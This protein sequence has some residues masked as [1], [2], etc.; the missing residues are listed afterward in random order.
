M[1]SAKPPTMLGGTAIRPVERHGMDKVKYFLH[2][3][4]TGEIMSRT[5]LSWLLITVFYVIY[6]LCLAAFWTICMVIFLQ[7]VPDDQ[8]KWQTT[9]GLIGESPGVGIRPKKFR[10]SH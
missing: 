7:T 1:A 2:N 8:P 9:N 3:P 4:D 6:Y 10:R 5:P